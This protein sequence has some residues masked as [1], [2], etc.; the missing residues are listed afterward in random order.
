MYRCTL[1]EKKRRKRGER[2]IERISIS[3]LT[4][5]NEMIRKKIRDDIE[6]DRKDKTST[7]SDLNDYI[8]KR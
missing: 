2:M 3:E 4:K 5:K 1:G 8:N 7:Q 6:R